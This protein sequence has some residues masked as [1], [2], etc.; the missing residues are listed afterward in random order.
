MTGIR[1]VT[2]LCI[3]VARDF[4]G[5]AAGVKALKGSVLILGPPGSGKTTLLR[6]LIRQAFPHVQPRIEVVGPV[7]GIYTGVGCV[8][9]AFKKKE[10]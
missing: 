6:D 5:I 7:V 9:I 8:G 3:R 1:E 10:G 4:P 2:G